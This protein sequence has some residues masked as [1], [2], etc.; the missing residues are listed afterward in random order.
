MPG[1]LDRYVLNTFLQQV[2]VN[3]TAE[4]Y[5]GG[6]GAAL[7]YLNNKQLTRA[8]FINHEKYG[9]IYKTG[10]YGKINEEGYIEYIGRIDSQAK[11]RGYRI[12]LG[13]IEQ[14]L[15]EQ[16]NIMHAYVAIKIINKTK[17]SKKSSKTF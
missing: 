2:P 6:M 12:E 15:L 9:R 4:I 13:E 8:S 10:D 14:L 3:T 17:S 16:H 1:L 5:I 7:S 11:L